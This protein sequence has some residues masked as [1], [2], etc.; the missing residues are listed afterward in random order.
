[1]PEEYLISLNILGILFSDNPNNE[2]NMALQV[3]NYPPSSLYVADHP[4]GSLAKFPEYQKDEKCTFHFNTNEEKK[5][6]P[7]ND[8]KDLAWEIRQEILQNKSVE[9]DA[10]VLKIQRF[11]SDPA[12]IMP[13]D[14]P[15]S[16]VRTIDNK[17]RCYLAITVAP[18]SEY[19][20]ENAAVINISHYNPAGGDAQAIYGYEVGC[21]DEKNKDTSRSLIDADEPECWLKFRDLLLDREV[22]VERS[23]ECERNWRRFRRIEL[24]KKGV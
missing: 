21:Y 20:W 15:Y 19:K 3:R 13:K 2:I 7:I 12:R 23:I 14:M 10:S 9:V 8:Y 5:E 1:M 24:P 4:F 6:R 22:E 18:V 16:A 17:G 11:M